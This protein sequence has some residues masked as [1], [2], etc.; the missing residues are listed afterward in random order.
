[1]VLE[2]KANKRIFIIDGYAL[3]YRS[4]FALIRNPLVTSYGLDTSALYGFINQILKII[5]KENPDYLVCAFDSKGKNFRHKMYDLYK[6]NRPEMPAE[7]QK[8]L[9]HLWDA[10]GALQIPVIKKKGVEADDIIGT[11][12]TDAE[13][14]G[15]ISFIVSG[16]KDF[17]QLINDKIFLY[18][19]GNRKSPNPIIYD[20]KKVQERWGVPPKKII[21]LLGLMG[22]ASD[23]VPGVAGIGE[24]TA[25]KLIM[26][27]GSMEGAID[28][29]EN[30]K[31]KRARNG[32]KEGVENAKLSK[33]LVTILKDVR[34][35]RNIKD[36][37]KNNIDLAACKKKFGELEFYAILKQLNNWEEQSF[38]EP[39]P[40][41]KKDYNIVLTKDSLDEMIGDL[42]KSNLISFD[43]LATNKLPIESKIIGL[44]FSVTKDK[45]YYVPLRY[46]EKVKNNF[47]EDD[48][49]IILRK[50]TKI[51]EDPSKLKTSHNIKF[52]SLILKKH[53]IDING[54][55]FD[56]VIAA[57][58]INPEA[59]S[60]SLDTLSLEFFGF[61]MIH[62]TDLIGKGRNQIKIVDVPLKK[63]AFYTSE[64]SDVCFQLTHLLMKRLEENGLV[65]YFKTIEIPLIKVLTEM[66]YFGT[67]VDPKLLKK[68]SQDIGQK[69]SYIVNSIYNLSGKD[70]NINST[71]QLATILFD[72]LDLPK[73]KSRSTAEPILKQLGELHELP[74][75]I[76]D[77]RKYF[78]LK[79]TYLDSLQ[80][81]ISKNTGRIHSTF[82]QTVTATGRLSSTNPNFQNIPIRRDEGKEIRRAFCAEKKNWKIF[83]FDY[84]QI[85]LR[86]MAHYSQ[87]DAMI[88]AFKENIDIHSQTASS[89]FS[90]PINNVLPEMRRTAKVVNFGIMY[91]AG[92]FRLSQELSVS[93]KE[94]SLIIT[95][96]FE[97]FPGIQN[98]ISDTLDGARHNKYVETIFGRR[99]PIWDVDSANAIKKKA[100]ERM[101]INMPIQGSAAEMIKVAMISI[102][103]K[104]NKLGMKSKLILQIHDELI[105]E[106]P[107]NEEEILIKMVVEKMENAMKLSVPIVVDYGSGF[108]WLEAH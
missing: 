102:Q 86:I 53:G 41:S 92:P 74:R 85:E 22:D 97:Q 103:D 65:S 57:H 30:V 36:F 95:K 27:Y 52:S 76:L 68:M 105:F 21:D 107:E 64:C 82:N 13:K 62:F 12:V 99:R 50:L 23:N 14:N 9:P 54:V 104:I 84:S 40:S 1:M 35:K 83:S 67:Y 31:N 59:K 29:L 106:S 81:L 38:T 37:K 42:N 69:L 90:V 28:N 87:D 24:K 94:A 60:F 73:I 7:L 47:G 91:G 77:Y 72:E 46:P 55:Y 16:D 98:Y 33:K 75:R 49:K 79:N 11:L 63:M 17:M 93:R 19:P 48:E 32:L 8:Q 26:E 51:F 45:A 96:Y 56:T 34:L 3:F 100:A 89:I 39:Y 101:A 66:E 18:A 25:V 71:Q 15:L 61:E 20:S 108:S 10:L 43:I 6:A 88:K 44:S 5:K 78:K 70:F 80:S 4:H 2:E 58:L